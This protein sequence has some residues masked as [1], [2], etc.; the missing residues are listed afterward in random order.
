MI[1]I[2]KQK[3]IFILSL[4]IY[5]FRGFILQNIYIYIF[6]QTKTKNEFK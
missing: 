2:F 4:N 6:N 1:L 3:N 5:L